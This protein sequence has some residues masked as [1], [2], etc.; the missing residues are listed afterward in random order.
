MRIASL[1]SQLTS[2]RITTLWSGVALLA[3]LG[4]VASIGRGYSVVE[5]MRSPGP[6]PELSRLD[7][8]SIRGLAVLLGEK[9]GTSGYRDLEAQ[10]RRFLAKFYVYPGAT[11]LHVMPG[12]AFMIL[13]PF[14]FSRQIRSR[15][16]RFHRWSGRV[17]AALAVPIGLSGLF[18]G[19]LMPFSGAK[20]AA[21]IALF[22]AIFLFA[23]ARAVMAIRRGD[24]ATHR[25]WMIR[26]FSIAIGISAVRLV[27]AVF[28]VVLRQGPEAWFG[29]SV[30]IGFGLTFGAAE[31]WIRRTR[32]PAIRSVEGSEV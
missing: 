25:E 5:S 28:L 14:Q 3:I 1:T 4:L 30:W 23:L 27:G 26:M 24:V 22:G 9:R 32:V 13:A 12:A 31:L 16:V 7:E 29:E 10:I 20:E 2:R 15:H 6:R 11:L 21:A 19:L 18:F 8:W 17:I